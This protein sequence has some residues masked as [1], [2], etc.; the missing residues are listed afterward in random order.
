LH[1]V[2]RVVIVPGQP[3]RQVKR[4]PQVRD[5]GLLELR[6]LRFFRHSP[7]YLCSLM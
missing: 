5:D 3:S 7:I 4:R 2:F 6:E 1:H